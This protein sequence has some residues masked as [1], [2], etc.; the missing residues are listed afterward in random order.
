MAAFSKDGSVA[1]IVVRDDVNPGACYVSGLTVYDEVLTGGRWIGRYWASN[2][3][4]AREEDLEWTT[5][6]AH[7]PTATA[8]ID[9]HAFGLEVDGQ[10][11]H[12]GWELEKIQTEPTGSDGVCRAVV[13]LKSSIRP[14][15]VDIH[16]EV[17]GTGF[18]TRWLTISNTG[19]NP[20]A[21]GAVWPWSGLLARTEDW[22]DLTDDSDDSVFTCGYMAD[23][24]WGREGAFQWQPLPRAA[25]RLESYMGK[26]GHGTPFF[27]VRNAASGEHIIG[28]LEWSGDWAIEL[29][30]DTETGTAL[31][32]FR[33]GPV[34]PAPM[35]VLDP[36]ETVTSPKVHLG[37]LFADLDAS[38]QAWHTHLRRSVLCPPP[39]KR[40]RRVYY[41][42]WGYH[43]QEVSEE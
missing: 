11:L 19:N 24:T 39:E 32:G 28:A 37:V 4:I 22:R 3:F 25:M 29:T 10:S 12:F 20:A 41:D 36:G 40:E 18:I 9:L 8:G 38:V 16:T 30:C 7:A 27:I 33:A 35:R 14:I 2:G 43:T 1:Q 31:L 34:C 13:K 23:R 42:H 15:T 6:A 26:S 5:G 17:D 21:L